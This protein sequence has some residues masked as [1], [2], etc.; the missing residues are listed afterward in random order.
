MT[1]GKRSRSA[2]ELPEGNIMFRSRV[3]RRLAGAEPPD[4]SPRR[5]PRK[6]LG[7]TLAAIASLAVGVVV[8][9]APQPA[10]ALTNLDGQWTVVHGGTGLISLNHDGSY[11][12]SCQVT[13][14]YDDAWCPAPAGTFERNSSGSSHVTFHGDDGST[15]SYRYSGEV[16][17]PDRITSTFT[18]SNHS[19]LDMRRGNYFTCTYWSDSGYRMKDS[20]LVEYDAG[21]GTLYA[22]GSHDLLGPA[23]ADNTVN[24]AETAPNYFQTGVTCPPPPPESTLRIASVT[25]ASRPATSGTRWVPLATVTVTDLTGAPVS[26]ADVRGRFDDGGN[27]LVITDCVTGTDGACL[28]ASG[29]SAPGAT[30]SL[31]FDAF[32]ATKVGMLGDE[33]HVFITLYN[34]SGTTTPST[35][36]TPPTTTPSTTST[37]PTTTPST[38]TTPPTTTPST[39]TPPAS[40][41][42]IGDLDDATMASWWSGWTR[43]WQPKVTAMVLDSN[44]APVAGATVNGTFSHYK[45]A[46]NCTTSTN[47]TCTLGNFSLKTSNRTTVFTVTSVTKPSSTYVSAANTD[48]D[49]ES[50]GTTITVNRP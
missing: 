19:S 26:G 38:T 3:S 10:D 30:T 28:M 34:P 12:S 25:D 46:V 20:P 44:G 7:V 22:T 49:G 15:T 31:S 17:N 5:P 14:G 47:G 18:S 24:L 42:H 50:N 41:H 13:P 33:A 39:T 4:R 27:F 43:K 9:G 23:T 40:T 1:A 32:S 21:T 8:V 2:A 6:R 48:P 45:A 29:Q 37:P 35:T 16:Q 36:S 11:T